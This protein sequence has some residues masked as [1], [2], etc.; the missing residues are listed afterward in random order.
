AKTE[1]T[2]A[3]AEP[4]AA[5]KPASQAAHKSAPEPPPR[6]VDPD[7]PVTCQCGQVT[8]QPRYV[9]FDM[10]WG[11][12]KRVQRRTLAGVFCR[13]CA[14]N[15]AIRATL[16]NWIAG[17]WAW[18]DGPRETIR[19]ILNNVRGGRMPADRNARLLMR[20]ARAFKTRGDLELAYNAALQA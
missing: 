6:R 17:W 19:A 10:V 3:R 12:L 8:A 2:E 14:D 5:P 1:R 15:A 9:L 18:P 20:Q 13:A 7:T 4:Q 16:V 11:Q